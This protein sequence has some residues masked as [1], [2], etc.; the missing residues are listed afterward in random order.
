MA[1]FSK[2]YCEL[3]D[4]GFDGDFDILEEFKLLEEDYYTSVI[5][6]GFGFSGIANIKGECMLYFP[7][8]DINKMGKWVN[9]NK[10][11]LSHTTP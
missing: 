6:E 4:M 10:L 1:E 5:C 7:S 2:Q 8:N 3:H 11:M 9:F